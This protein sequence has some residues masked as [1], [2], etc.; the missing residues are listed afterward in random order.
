MSVP[1]ISREFFGTLLAFAVEYIVSFS[2]KDRVV[3]YAVKHKLI[4]QSRKLTIKFSFI[5]SIKSCVQYFEDFGNTVYIQ[6]CVVGR[7]VLKTC[8]TRMRIISQTLRISFI[9]VAIA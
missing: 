6:I 4:F 5:N 7:V 8:Y 1:H 2:K 9:K 3:A